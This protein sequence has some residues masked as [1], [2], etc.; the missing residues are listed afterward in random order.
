ML[1][2]YPVWHCMIIFLQ[3]CKPFFFYYIDADRSL[4]KLLEDT[5][6]N[7]GSYLAKLFTACCA[8]D[9]GSCIIFFLILFSHTELSYE[10]LQVSRSKVYTSRVADGCGHSDTSWLSSVAFGERTTIEHRWLLIVVV[11]IRLQ[12]TILILRTRDINLHTKHWVVSAWNIWCQFLR[13]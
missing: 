7:T 6:Q 11:S 3:V 2:T 13:S 4:G 8:W 12:D 9:Q 1:L 10:N 5:W